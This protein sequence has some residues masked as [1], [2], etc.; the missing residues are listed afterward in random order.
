MRATLAIFGIDAQ[1]G[2]LH[3]WNPHGNTFKPKGPAGLEHGYATKGGRFD[4]PLGDF[5]ATFRGVTFET[6][7]ALANPEEAAHLPGRK[8]R[9][10]TAKADAPKSPEQT[11]HK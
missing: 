11:T 7:E 10:P 2:V 6:G 5:V 3:L 8:P 9:T 1:A 4:M